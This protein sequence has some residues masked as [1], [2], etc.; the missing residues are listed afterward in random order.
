MVKDTEACHLPA[1]TLGKLYQLFV[2]LFSCLLNGD[3]GLIGLFLLIKS[4]KTCKVVRISRAHVC[5][6]EEM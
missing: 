1:V 6:V 5:K 4:N 3:K 2:P